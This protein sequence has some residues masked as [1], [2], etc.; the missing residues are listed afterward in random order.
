MKYYLTEKIEWLKLYATNNGNQ[1][2]ILNAK[3]VDEFSDKFECKVMIQPFGANKC[4][5]LAH[6]LSL[7]YKSN[8]LGRSIVSLHFHEV[9]FPNWVYVYYFKKLNE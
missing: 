5:E 3:L 8:L 4:K 7:A 6:T 2:D 1:L 9:G